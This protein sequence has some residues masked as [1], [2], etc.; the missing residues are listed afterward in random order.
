MSLAELTQSQKDELA[1]SLAVLAVHD[2][3]VEISAENL[4][5]A[6][7]ASGNKVAA[8]VPQLFADLIAR[9]L[10]VGKFL[11]GPS[12]GGAAPAA[13]ASAGAAAAAAPEEKEE[14]EEADLGGGMD[15]F[16]GG[17]DY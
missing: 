6:L 3:K 5:A 8:F 16:G 17:S 9:G 15:M 4:T 10:K 14:E 7:E 13:G 1:T 2:A 12:A 11:A